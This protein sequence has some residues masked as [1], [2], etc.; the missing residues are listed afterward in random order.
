MTT[1]LT[2][3]KTKFIHL[4]LHASSQINNMQ[5]TTDHIQKVK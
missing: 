2:R 1:I 5:Q 3:S 4:S